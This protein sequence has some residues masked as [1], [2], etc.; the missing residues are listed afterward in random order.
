MWNEHCGCVRAVVFRLLLNS[1][2]GVVQDIAHVARSQHP[3]AARRGG[4]DSMRGCSVA[5]NR[6]AAR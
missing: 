6:A 1:S 2:P 3:L 5:H 4:D